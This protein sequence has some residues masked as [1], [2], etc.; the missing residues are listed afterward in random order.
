[1]MNDSN[2]FSVIIPTFNREKVLKRAIDSVMNQ[3]YPDFDLWIIDDG[4]TDMT[5][6]LVHQYR[7][8]HPL[9]E[10]IF[11][12]KIINQGVSAARNVGIH[13]SEGKWLAFLDSDD[14]WLPDK[15]Y[16]QKKLIDANPDLKIVHGEEIW[17]RNG[18]RVNPKKIHQKFGGNIYKL[19]LPLC[20]ISPSAAVV[21]R[22]ML[23]Q[24]GNFDEE[25]VVCED[26]YLWLKITSL[27]EVG[28]I[29]DP[30]IKKYGGHAD[31]LSHQYHSMDYYRVL[32]MYK[33][34]KMRH[35]N[36][37]DK[38]ATLKEIISKSKILIKGYL[39]HH[40]LKNLAEI[41]SISDHARA[42]LME[43]GC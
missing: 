24:M 12:Q 3:S 28:F 32:A 9:K 1:M 5:Q 2:F 26:Y 42:L 35:L 4:S 13:I 17:I 16:K 15:L 25:F 27:Y 30:L 33:M 31:Q 34:L 19:C 6:E 37:D 23:G 8:H 39:K 11:Y 10:K 18:V 36:A 43:M 21:E 38:Q 41:K 14:E 20:L 29:V 7:Q 22:E 40:N